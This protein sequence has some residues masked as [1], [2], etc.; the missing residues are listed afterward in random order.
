MVPTRLYHALQHLPLRRILILAL[1]ACSTASISPSTA[2]T[3]PPHYL[4]FISVILLHHPRHL[5]QTVVTNDLR[6]MNPSSQPT[7]RS[8]HA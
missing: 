2:S 7:L 8:R 4:L 3:L 6:P 5:T 1:L